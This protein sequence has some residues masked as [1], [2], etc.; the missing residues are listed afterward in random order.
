MLSNAVGVSGC[1]I[2]RKKHYEGVS[3]NV[4]SITKMLVG[5][6]F[7]GK[8]LYVTFERPLTGSIYMY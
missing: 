1:Q 6:N 8:K 5:V 3:L 4:I 7:P 2:S